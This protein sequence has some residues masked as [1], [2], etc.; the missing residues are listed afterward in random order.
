MIYLICRLLLAVVL[1]PAQTLELFAAKSPN[2]NSSDWNSQLYTL[3]FHLLLIIFLL[4]SNLTILT[5]F[6]IIFLS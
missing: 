2:I 3:L 6:C 5:L 1:S 4:F